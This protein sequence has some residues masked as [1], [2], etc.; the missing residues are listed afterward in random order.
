M[1]QTE[2]LAEKT[3]KKTAAAISEA[4]KALLRAETV[5]I[6]GHINPDG[7]AAGAAFALAFA[8]KN[9][10][11]RPVVILDEYNEKFDILPGREF[12]PAFG[13]ADRV[14]LEQD[15]DLFV[16]VDCA[17]LNR[18]TAQAKDIMSRAKDSL[19]V[20]HHVLNKEPFAAHNVIDPEKCAACEL[21]F[22]IINEMTPI[23]QNIA[24]AL[25]AGIVFDSGRFLHPSVS[26]ATFEVAAKLIST[27]IRFSEI[28][29]EITQTHSILEAKLL[30]KALSALTLE[31]AIAKL[32]ITLD[33]FE[34]CGGSSKDLD[35]IAEYALN[36]RG[37]EVAAFLYEKST[38]E[39][40][41]SLRSKEINVRNVARLFGGGGHERA[42]GCSINATIEKA[43][44]LIEPALRN[45]MNE[46]NLRGN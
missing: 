17:E 29:R 46:A 27:G 36:T 19:C 6:A 10:K 14:S 28:T 9:L 1:K 41:V 34:Q 25:Y 26:P 8:L 15:F 16:A 13:D 3:N 39:V 43:F 18:I 21:M 4:V 12:L 7:D 42:A 24:S 38:D 5:A 20:D 11:K 31:G 2:A 33:D 32:F 44:H 40:K 22:H 23:D 35:G 37:A 45:E 30:A